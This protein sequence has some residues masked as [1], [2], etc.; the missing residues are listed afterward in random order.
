MF[1]H[2]VSEAV[3]QVKV[4]GLE[5]RGHPDWVRRVEG[6]LVGVLKLESED[7]MTGEREKTQRE[8]HGALA[9]GFLLTIVFSASSYLF[10]TLT[11]HSSHLEL[12]TNCS[13]A[14]LTRYSFSSGG[15][16]HLE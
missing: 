4:P 10:A 12:S 14:N 1:V 5:F 9:Q 3:S 8:R 11:N 6:D 2:H 16:E 13:A 7:C 15:L